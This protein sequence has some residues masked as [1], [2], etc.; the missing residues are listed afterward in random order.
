MAREA[1][2]ASMELGVDEQAMLD[3]DVDEQDQMVPW[4]QQDQMRKDQ[5]G[6]HR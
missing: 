2:S 1:A 5:C 3:L 4:Q 6:N